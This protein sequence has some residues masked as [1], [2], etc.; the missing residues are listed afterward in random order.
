MFGKEHRGCYDTKM[1]RRNGANDVW[2][3]KARRIRNETAPETQASNPMTRSEC[4]TGHSAVEGAS[5]DDEGIFAFTRPRSWPSTCQILA[6]RSEEEH[7]A[8]DM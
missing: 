4:R 7:L 1:G 5:L 3:M 2:M 8:D 6:K